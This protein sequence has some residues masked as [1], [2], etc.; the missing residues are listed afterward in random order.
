[1]AACQTCGLPGEHGSTLACVRALQTDL[2]EE[3]LAHALTAQHRDH[4]HRALIVHNIKEYDMGKEFDA[5]KQAVAKVIAEA[6][7]KPSVN[8]KPRMVRRSVVK[9]A[10]KQMFAQLRAAAI[11]DA[12]AI[13]DATEGEFDA[14][15][16][17]LEHKD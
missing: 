6:K 2:H 17:Q 9:A 8:P 14:I 3:R 7:A 15:L 16:D 11:Q 13:L 10:A 12:P 4:Y 5:G 1:M